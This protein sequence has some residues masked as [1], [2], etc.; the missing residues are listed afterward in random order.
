MEISPELAQ[1]AIKGKIA[2]PLKLSVE[3][4]ALGIYQVCRESMVGGMLEMTV[5][6][7]IDPREFVIVA[8][9][10][11]TSMCAA[12]LAQEVGVEKIVIPKVASE[13]CAFGA[14]NADVGL[15]SVASRYTD[16]KAFDYDGINKVL[17]GLKAK[18][19]AFLA[20]LPP[21]DRKL[22]YYCAARYPM[23]VTDLEVALSGKRMDSEA[24][25]KAAEDFHKA[26]LARYKT[27]DPGSEVEFVMWRHVASTLTPKIELEKQAYN[28][29]SP[30]K[31]LMGRQLAYF[32]GEQGF[33]ETPYYDG[34]NMT[35]GMSIDGP[36]IIVLSD[37]TIVVPPGYKVSTQ[38]YGY[39]IMEVPVSK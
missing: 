9:G 29:E 39:F 1:K 12:G 5:R 19:Q 34:E 35:Y 25:S 7:G 18:G 33:I 32:E 21:G 23:Q 4:A 16:T 31:V 22:E 17:E 2:E 11:A 36:A 24:V 28:A 10:G 13:L 8:G 15:S 27:C 30:S 26:S 37:T 6:R 14:L 38:E 20:P 3:E